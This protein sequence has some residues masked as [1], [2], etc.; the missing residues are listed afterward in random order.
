[1][2]FKK[3]FKNCDNWYLLNVLCKLEEGQETKERRDK[4]GQGLLAKKQ[5]LK[6]SVT[7]R[8][9]MYTIYLLCINC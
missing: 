1:M 9:V 5:T 8:G 4:R 7:L 3:T 2:V 6:T